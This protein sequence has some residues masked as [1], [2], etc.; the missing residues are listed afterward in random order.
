MKEQ[1]FTDI[2]GEELIVKHRKSAV[3]FERKANIEKPNAYNAYGEE[4]AEYVCIT[5]LRRVYNF[6][7]EE[8]KRF[9]DYCKLI[10]TESWMNF[11]PKE[12]DSFGA[13]YDD[14]YDKEFDNNGSLSVNATT[15]KIEGPYAQPKSKGE[16]IR[17]IKFNK[18]KFESFIYD[19]NR[20]I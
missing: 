14:Y 12:V 17:L 18:R 1:I 13:D 10:S 16:I 6:S 19:L 9:C 20:L 3:F 11:T 7:S 2:N 5:E 8:F 15:I 4:H